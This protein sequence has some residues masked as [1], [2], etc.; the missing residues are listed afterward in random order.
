MLWWG[1]SALES[2]Y[3]WYGGLR[4]N[5]K[6]IYLLSQLSSIFFLFDE[7]LGIIQWYWLLQFSLPFYLPTVSTASCSNNSDIPVSGQTKSTD[8]SAAFSE[9]T[10][11]SLE[12]NQLT[13]AELPLFSFSTIVIATNNFSE[14]NKLGQ[15]G[16]GPVY[17]VNMQLLKLTF[18]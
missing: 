7:S 8:L 12:E 9:S 2:L 1:W 10:D 16:F 4:E 3:G 18:L 17:K 6:V 11:F 15:G 14:E 5:S 13:R